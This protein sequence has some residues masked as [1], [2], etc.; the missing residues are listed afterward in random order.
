MAPKR[1]TALEAWGKELGHA[2]DAA[3]M[4]ARQLAKSLTVAPS[5]ISQW[6]NGKRTPHLEDVKRC[7]DV[8]GTNGFLARYYERW[9]TREI[10]SEWDDAWLAAEGLANLIQNYELSV[11]PGLLQ[12]ENYARAVMRFTRHSPIDVEERVHRRV[13]RQKILTDE[14]PPMCIFV[15]DEYAL[16]RL[17]GG[18]DVMVEQLAYLCECAK[19][20]N[21]VAKVIPAGIEYYSTLPFMIAEL[22]NAKLVNV[23]DI[24]SG[25]VVEGNGDVVEAS[26]IW[27]DVREAALPPKDSMKLI[28]KVIEE[29]Q[30]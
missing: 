27:E 2:C 18:P 7:D 1:E 16:R 14:N 15:I 25:R 28:E 9:V 21:I 6:M 12:T 11:I 22:D 23:D 20:P 17:V 29:W 24:L 30:L 26:K 8:L 4:T 5:T 3:K 19:R 13:V 10:P